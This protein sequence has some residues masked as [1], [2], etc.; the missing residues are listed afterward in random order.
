VLPVEQIAARLDDRFR[1]LTGGAR[2]AE[3]RQRTLRAAID[4]SYELLNDRERMLFRRLSVFVGGFTLDAAEAVCSGDG[5]E[6]DLVLDLLT[7][8]VDR[9][10]VM[11]AVADGAGGESRFW[12]LETVRQYAGEALQQAGE[13]VTIRGRHLEFFLAFALRAESELRGPQQV[14]WLNA[15]ER[16]HDNVRAAIKWGQSDEGTGAAALRLAGALR[17]FWFMR[18]H[19]TEGREALES[20]LA[21]GQRGAARDE[22]WALSAAALLAWRQRDYP[23]ATSLAERSEVLCR[24]ANDDRTCAYALNVLALVARDQGELQRAEALHQETL[25]LFT[26]A[27]DRWGTALADQNLAYVAHRRGDSARAAALAEHALAIFRD[28]KD[29]WG[30]ATT[31]FILGRMALRQGRETRAAEL[32]HEAMAL[33]HELGDRPLFSFTQVSLGQLAVQQGNHERARALL[34]E[35]LASLRE[36]ADKRGIADA[37]A[38]LGLL[39]FERGDHG[40]AASMH[41]ESLAL[42]AELGNRQGIAEGLEWLANLAIAESRLQDAAVLLGAADALREAIG[43]P[44]PEASR[45]LVAGAVSSARGRLGEVAFDAAWSRG[46]TM[47][48]QQAVRAALNPAGAV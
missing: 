4:W 3:R 2:T 21:G 37:T 14:E 12:M 6:S 33:F 15:L 47:P 7:R 39:A 46:R 34:E 41:R 8:L 11:S 24:E 13:W 38:Y 27:G 42:N 43:A 28:V 23:A 29:R 9:S 10:L 44:V 22:A 35:S 32:F 36:M 30:V 48:L 20:A 17:W 18:G 1:L 5:C 45:G 16:E 40:T 31:E 26:R 25:E 19:L